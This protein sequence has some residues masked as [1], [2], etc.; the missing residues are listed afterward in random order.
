MIVSDIEIFVKTQ[1]KKSGN[2]VVRKIKIS[3]KMKNKSWL[4]KK[5]LFWDVQEDEL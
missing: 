4:S 3:K 1:K 5:I 2:M